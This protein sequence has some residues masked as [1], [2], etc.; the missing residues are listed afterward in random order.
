LLA[1]RVALVEEDF[2]VAV[3]AVVVAEAGNAY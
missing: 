3:L 2:R 1:K